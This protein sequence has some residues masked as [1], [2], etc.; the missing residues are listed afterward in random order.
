MRIICCGNRDRGDDAAGL[1]VAELLRDMGIDA[2]V[3][4][5]DPLDM[6][7]RW[8]SADDVIVV[9]AMLTGAPAGTVRSFEGPLRA[10]LSGAGCSS[11]GLGVGEAICLAEVLGRLPRR[12]RVYG[13]EGERFEA[14]ASI[15]QDVQKAAENLAR[16]IAAEALPAADTVGSR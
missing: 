6:M 16:R 15:S 4:G 7:D 1:M 14:G 8:R 5:G 11:H 10:N 12:L 9:D 13:I 3:C 2:E